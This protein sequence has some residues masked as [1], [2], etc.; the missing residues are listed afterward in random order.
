M[1]LN[2]TEKSTRQQIC[3]RS[4]CS[5]KKRA[6]CV[7]LET[8]CSWK[9]IY[10]TIKRQKVPSTLLIT[11]SSKQYSVPSDYIGKVVDIYA[12]GSEIYIYHNSILITV[13]SLS[14]DNINYKNEHYVDALN[15]RLKTETDAIEELASKN[16]ERLKR[17]GGD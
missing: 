2:V 9:I 17:L 1:Q 5:R 13:H 10:R 15:R 8:K 16:L 4:H 6:F 3:R 7:R 11:Y 12:V 14:K